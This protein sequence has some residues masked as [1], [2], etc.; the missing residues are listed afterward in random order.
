MFSDLSK[1]NPP[2]TMEALYPGLQV[3]RATT[4]PSFTTNINYVT[5][6]TN[7]NGAPY[8]SPPMLVTKA[9]STNYLWVTNWHYSFGNVF[10]NHY[11]TNRYHNRSKHHDQN[12][13]AR[14]MGSARPH[15]QYHDLQDQPGVP[16]TFSSSRPTGAALICNWPFR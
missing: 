4:F 9:V 5:Y 15:D 8:S 11:Y 10:T 16:A 3:L 7:Q 1:T 12:L 13:S 14:P 2:A 6:L